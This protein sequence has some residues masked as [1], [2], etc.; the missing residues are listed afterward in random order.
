MKT[1]TPL[2]LS[3][4]LLSLA[5]LVAIVLFRSVERAPAAQSAFHN[6]FQPVLTDAHIGSF[7]DLPPVP[8]QPPARGDP[9]PAAPKTAKDPAP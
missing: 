2:I 7:K 8:L 6:R 9:P 1:R 3:A 4:A 5:G